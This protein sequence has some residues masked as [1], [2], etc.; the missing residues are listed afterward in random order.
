MAK[1]KVE[2]ET[3]TTSATEKAEIKLVWFKENDD[4]YNVFFFFGDSKDALDD[5]RKKLDT[6]G[7]VWDNEEYPLIIKKIKKIHHKYFDEAKYFFF[8]TMHDNETD[9]RVEEDQC[10]D[11]VDSLENNQL[12]LLHATHEVKWAK[13]YAEMILSGVTQ[14]YNWKLENIVTFT[15][16]DKLGI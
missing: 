14:A 13:L 7:D 12:C 2:L 8:R 5:I 1:K 3:A 10:Q 6:N 15:E 16:I 11:L 9:A 4:Y